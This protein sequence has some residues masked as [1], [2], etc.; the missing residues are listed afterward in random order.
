MT[1]MVT[2][3]YSHFLY[4][5]LE[6]FSC[7]LMKEGSG[8]HL[9]N[10]ILHEERSLTRQLIRAACRLKRILKSHSQKKIVPQDNSSENL[11]DLASKAA[12][13]LHKEDKD[14][15]FKNLVSKAKFIMISIPPVSY[16]HLTLPT[17][18]IV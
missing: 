13:H 15:S 1:R 17:K 10:P 12:S 5:L 4:T 11:A 6:P 16:T 14:G 2:S 18:R 7:V 9:K 8:I 3:S